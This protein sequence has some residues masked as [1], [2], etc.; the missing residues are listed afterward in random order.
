MEMLAILSLST[1]THLSRFLEIKMS[2]IPAG[3]DK[4]IN[5]KLMIFQ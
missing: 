1:A 3:T 2:N 4:I 5:D